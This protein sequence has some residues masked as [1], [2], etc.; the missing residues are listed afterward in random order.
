MNSFKTIRS[1]GLVGLAI[2]IAVN[3]V[4]LLLLKKPSAEFFSDNWWLDWFPAYI[5]W[6]VCSIIGVAGCRQK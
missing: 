4:A 2:V 1:V 3:F 6:L 5:V